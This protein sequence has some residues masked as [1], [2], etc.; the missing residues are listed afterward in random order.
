MKK[1]AL[2]IALAVASLGSAQAQEFGPRFFIGTGLTGGGDTLAT[3]YYEDD[4]ERNIKAGGLI[5]FGAGVD[6]RVNDQFSMQ[7]SFNYHFDGENSRSNDFKYSRSP[8]ELMAYWHPAQN[9]RIGGGARY[10]GNA[11]VEDDF[12]SIKFEDTVGAVIEAEYLLG[13]HFGFKLRYVSEKY[14]FKTP[15]ETYKVD[16]NHV[17]A[18]VNYY[19]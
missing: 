4:Y 14:E 9:W 10:V 12:D 5:Q 8:I 13:N 15:F 19:F 16:G 6:F 2:M 17:G 18:F 7:A 11:K 3:A 1:I